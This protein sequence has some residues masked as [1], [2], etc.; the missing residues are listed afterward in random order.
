[1]VSALRGPLPAAHTSSTDVEF[2]APPPIDVGQD[3]LE[4]ETPPQPPWCV[5]GFRLA[6]TCKTEHTKVYLSPHQRT[7]RGGVH[8]QWCS[9]LNHAPLLT[10]TDIARCRARKPVPDHSVTHETRMCCDQVVHVGPAWLLLQGSLRVAITTPTEPH[11]PA[12]VRPSRCRVIQS[13]PTAPD[14]AGP[15]TAFD[16]NVKHVYYYYY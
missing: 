16:T 2:H 13:Q 1:M 15:G 4:A 5:T 11:C 12:R 3:S 6:R 7:H 14:H 8:A 9:G 10:L